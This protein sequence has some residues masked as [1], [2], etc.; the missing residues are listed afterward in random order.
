MKPE[1]QTSLVT[2]I[3]HIAPR[4]SGRLALSLIAGAVCA[5]AC[6]LAPI[7]MAAA[8][9]CEEVRGDKKLTLDEAALSVKMQTSGAIASYTVVEDIRLKQL[10]GH[11]VSGNES[12]AFHQQ[13]FGLTIEF[14]A[15]GKVQRKKFLC[16]DYKYDTPLGRSC[17]REVKQIDWAAPSRVRKLYE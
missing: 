8:R 17:D 13:L 1:L 7:S 14:T 15:G 3:R 2:S 5:V 12:F 11:C 6:Q 16:L 10:K 9:E 4:R